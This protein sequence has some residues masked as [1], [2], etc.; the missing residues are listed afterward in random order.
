M[1]VIEGG[2]RGGNML[3]GAVNGHPNSKEARADTRLSTLCF[4]P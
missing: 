4:L 2:G 3:F 1:I